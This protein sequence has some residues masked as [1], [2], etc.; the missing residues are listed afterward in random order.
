[1]NRGLRPLQR[2]GLWL[3]LWL[4]AI[5]AV[6]AVCLAPAADLPSVPSG[7]DKIEHFLAYFLLSWAAVQLFA[8]RA[9]VARAMVGL[10]LL[11]VAIEF[12]QGAFTVDRSADVFDA[13]ADTAGVLAG[14]ALLPTPLRGVLQ[15]VDGWLFARGRTPGRG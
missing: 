12:A 11:G 14:L 4:A 15:R 1:M 13:L 5:V 3:A 8:G 2:P 7:G 6:V 10:V 9:A